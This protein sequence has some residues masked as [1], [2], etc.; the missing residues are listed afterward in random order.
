MGSLV[1]RE[2]PPLGDVPCIEAPSGAYP[3]SAE[4][5]V[6]MCGQAKKESLGLYY[7]DVA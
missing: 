3:M 4:V 2:G 5:E 6:Q 1:G 7:D